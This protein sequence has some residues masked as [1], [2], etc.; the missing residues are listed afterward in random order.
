MVQLAKKYGMT[1]VVLSSM[2]LVAGGR[3]SRDEGAPAAEVCIATKG[4]NTS[5]WRTSIRSK[6]RGIDDIILC[7]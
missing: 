1:V 2:S 4:I 7:L 3:A 5:T 6:V